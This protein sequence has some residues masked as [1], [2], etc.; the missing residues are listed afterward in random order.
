MSRNW[1]VLDREMTEQIKF[2]KSYDVEL[3]KCVIYDRR[4]ILLHTIDCIEQ[5][6]QGAYVIKSKHYAWIRKPKND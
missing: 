3:D 4:A 1:D 5:T 6:E 2:Y